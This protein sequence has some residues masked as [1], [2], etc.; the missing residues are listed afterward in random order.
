[1]DRHE[2]MR[3]HFQYN[4]RQGQRGGNHEVTL[5]MRLFIGFARFCLRIA[6]QRTL[7]LA[8][9]I[10][11][12]LDRFDQQPNVGRPRD[13]GA[14]SRQIDPRCRNARHCLHR[15]F[16]PRDTGR[17][18]HTAD[19]QIDRLCRD[20]VARSLDR[21]DQAAAINGVCRSNLGLLGGQ[22]DACRRDAW[23]GPQGAFDPRDARCT[24][25]PLNWQRHRRGIFYGG[26][27]GIH[28]GD[29]S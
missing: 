3:A 10:A 16:N 24:G 5:Q 9:V 25:H 28:R 19:D 22:V 2:R 13:R 14:F 6:R 27:M 26:Q 4:D 1:M 8:G 20:I 12:I 11:S 17:A 7:G 23:H 15:S 21:S 29:L 18:S